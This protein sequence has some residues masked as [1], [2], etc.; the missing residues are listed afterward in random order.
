MVVTTAMFLLVQT[1]TSA[2]EVCSK[3]LVLGNLITWIQI[4]KMLLDA[5]LVPLKLK[6]YILVIE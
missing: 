3:W 6:F 5:D 4:L 2:C 1:A